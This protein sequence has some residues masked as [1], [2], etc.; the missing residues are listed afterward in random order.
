MAKEHAIKFGVSKTQQNLKRE[1]DIDYIVERSRKIGMLPNNNRVPTY[2]D[3]SQ[4]PDYQSAL[5]IVINA[6][7]QFDL[8][9]SKIR[10]RFRNDPSEMMAFLADPAN[11]DEA[12]KLGMMT[13]SEAKKEESEKTPMAKAETA[14]KADQAEA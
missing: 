11:I 6:Q 14:K 10:K 7:K 1:T 8:L 2:Q 13:K 9:D 5:H 4:V 3:V 12:V